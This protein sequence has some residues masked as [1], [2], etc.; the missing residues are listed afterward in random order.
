MPKP[1][2][3]RRVE[4]EPSAEAQT[5]SAD[6]RTGSE[7]VPR[8]PA[9]SSDDPRPVRSRRFFSAEQKRAIVAEAERCTEPG[10]IGALLRKHGIYSGTLCKWRKS[11][12]AGKVRGSGRPSVRDDKDREI[13]EL[14]KRNAQ[15]ESRVRR[16]EGLVEVQ[17]KAISLLD[18]M[19]SSWYALSAISRGIHSIIIAVT[20]YKLI[21]RSGISFCNSLAIDRL[22]VSES[23]E[24]YR[25]AWM[26]LGLTVWIWSMRVRCFRT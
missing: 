1:T 6:P 13:T 8:A 24:A 11:V 5:S 18:A 7:G 4:S 15:L 9:V 26:T 10:D 19:A 23:R 25:N 14:R 3:S 2:P 22:S 21:S 17:K 16:A 20:R 12:A